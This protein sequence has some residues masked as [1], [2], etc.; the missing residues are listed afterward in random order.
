MITHFTQSYNIILKDVL[1]IFKKI[2][3]VN[4]NTPTWVQKNGKES[5]II[6]I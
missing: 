3:A 4:K 5:N 1:F 2:F 6:M